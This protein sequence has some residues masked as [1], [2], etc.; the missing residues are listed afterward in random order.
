MASP[1]VGL[2]ERVIG[3][4]S[5]II[6][7]DLDRFDFRPA[8]HAILGHNHLEELRD[9]AAPVVIQ[10]PD[11]ASRFHKLFYDGFDQ[12]AVT[13]TE[14]VK[15]VAEQLFTVPTV[16]YQKVPTFRV[17]LPGDMPVGEFHRDRDYNHQDGEI[18]CWVPLTRAYG[19]NTIWI[20]TEHSGYVPWDLDVGQALI[21]DAVNLRHGNLI[22]TTPHSRVSF[23][24][25]MID[26]ADYTDSGKKTVSAG[27]R[28]AVGDYFDVIRL[29][30][31]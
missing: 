11:Q 3:G 25:R 30:E 16:F 12:L 26:P 4:A 24:F 31:L 28:R 20:E 8:A 15:H 14:F 23:D 21:F 9:D 5:R 1:E 13:Y 17:H 19:S 29:R 6:D 7:Y 18:N 22:N 27:R 10:Q 2:R